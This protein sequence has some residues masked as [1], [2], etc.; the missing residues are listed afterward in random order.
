M[1]TKKSNRKITSL[2]GTRREHGTNKNMA[3][4]MTCFVNVWRR[5]YSVCEPARSRDNN[6]L[7]CVKKVP[8]CPNGSISTTASGQMESPNHERLTDPL[9]EMRRDTTMISSSPT[10]IMVCCSAQVDC[11][12][13]QTVKRCWC[14]MSTAKYG[15]EVFLTTKQTRV[16]LIDFAF[17]SKVSSENR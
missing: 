11:G 2:K 12:G 13:C 16:D 5:S 4:S 9:Q 1:N 17:D 3:D 7:S 15:R 6:N 10:K 14:V 8:S